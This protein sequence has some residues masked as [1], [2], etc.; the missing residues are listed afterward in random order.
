MRL[1]GALLGAGN[2]ALRSHLPQ[3]LANARLREE[4]QL[5]A[6]ADLSA[7]NLARAHELLPEARLYASAAELLATESLDFCDICTPPFTHAA[8]VSQAAAA[9]L[10]VV[11]E[12]PLAPTV[13]QAEA[14]ERAV[15][16]SGIVFQPCH[17]YHH[18]PQWQA[19]LGWLP[20]IGRVYLAEYE[21]QRTAA[22]EGNANWSPA[23]RTDPSLA[24]GGILADHGAHILYQ[25]RA[26][27]G[28]PETVQAT[29]RTLHHTSY[30]VE[31]TAL[32]T[33]DYGDCLGHLSLSWASRRRSIQFRFVGEHGEISG[34]DQALRINADTSEE[35]RFASGLSK[36]SS[37]AEW[38]APLLAGFVERVRSGRRDMDALH[39]AAYVTR[40]IAL[41]YQSSAEER[42]LP[43]AAP[44]APAV[45]EPS[46]ARRVEGG[47]FASLSL[48]AM[49]ASA[50]SVQ[51]DG[52]SPQRRRRTFA[53]RAA[54]AVALLASAGW[55]FHDVHAG[56]VWASMASASPGWLA[57]AAGVNILVL[58]SQSARWLAL[59]KP[60]APRTSLGQ[61]FKSTII[62]YAV[63]SV[64]PARAGE[65][66]RIELLG[67]Y[68]GLSR[69]AIL[70]SVLL[71]QLVNASFLLVGVAVLPLLVHVP[72]WLRQGGW[73]ALALFVTGLVV[74]FGL[75]P[76]PDS[77][78]GEG[79]ARASRFP[80]R[81]VANALTR[82]RSGLLAFR[83]PSALGYS[84][85][86][87]AISWGLEVNVTVL[88]LRAV[89][90]HLPLVASLL[91]LIAVNLALALP[92]APPGNLGTLELGATLALLEFGIKKEQ[93]LAFALCYHFLQVIPIGI[94][95]LILITRGFAARPA[96]KPA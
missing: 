55:A 89:G 3:W 91:V 61:A 40:L 95:G 41:A 65:V 80:L 69:M 75:R 73:F 90:L 59:V 13:A 54:A 44:L 94:I 71:D 78:Q 76:A 29:V 11:C 31:D 12:K 67:R 45:G 96:Q 25:L 64:V 62:G 18:S 9:G 48:S 47:A 63:S 70:G 28:E 49:T 27:L 38:Y 26:V 60:L 1:R 36:D 2:I 66:A 92:F 5:V 42:A 87:S 39:E 32:V 43:L 16:R 23:W 34:D 37:H 56:A 79:G 57:L 24:G 15:E 86:A 51:A 33:L 53:L 46:G 58:L 22:N 72:L 84:L 6:V 88:S 77:A 85:G 14:I 7:T 93:A 74:V 50:M 68:T 21:V 8:L 35:L 10:H 81:T 4:T 30:E 82:V 83:K 52:P 19:L 17:Q 20:R